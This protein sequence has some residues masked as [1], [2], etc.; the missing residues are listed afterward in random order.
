LVR[1]ANPLPLSTAFRSATAAAAA[2]DDDDDDE[3]DGG[4][5][6]QLRPKSLSGS[7]LR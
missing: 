6:F 4:L 1:A 3:L 2:S 5:A 7:R